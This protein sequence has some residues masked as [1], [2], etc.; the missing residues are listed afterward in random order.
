MLLLVNESIGCTIVQGLM[1]GKVCFNSPCSTLYKDIYC[2]D[3][4]DSNLA[5]KNNI[6]LYQYTKFQQKQVNSTL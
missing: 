3:T 2:T 4:L 1:P 6:Q 5:L